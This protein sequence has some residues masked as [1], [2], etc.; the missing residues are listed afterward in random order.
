MSD[1]V[2]KNAG[3]FHGKID[4]IFLDREGVIAHDAVKRQGMKTVKGKDIPVHILEV[5]GVKVEM[6]IRMMSQ[7]SFQKATN[8]SLHGGDQGPAMNTIRYEDGVWK[9]DI[10]VDQRLPLADY[11]KVIGHEFDEIAGIVAKE[12]SRIQ[13]GDYSD[14]SAALTR[15]IHEQQEARVFK[16]GGSSKPEDLT[17]HDRAAMNELARLAN[18]VGS[19]RAGSATDGPQ[20]HKDFTE[21]SRPRAQE[22]SLQKMLDAM[23]ITGMSDPRVKILLDTV[24][25]NLTPD[26]QRWLTNYLYSR[27]L[28]GPFTPKAVDHLLQPN[29]KNLDEHSWSL[30]GIGGGHDTTSLLDMVARAP[31]VDGNPQFKLEHP[32]GKEPF[33]EITSSAGTTKV[34]NWEQYQYVSGKGYVK[35]DVPKTSVDNPAVHMAYLKEFHDAVLMPAIGDGKLDVGLNLLE[36]KDGVVMTVGIKSLNPLEITTIFINAENF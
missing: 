12:N 25:A 19:N 29:P 9:A 17:A 33:L 27:E 3:E 32:P 1:G 13:A 16:D 6:N 30:S 2:A 24:G 28:G 22:Q 20:H 36:N 4:A 23:G 26:A 8:A 15:N 14:D 10:V 5:K 31:K 35:S 11:E 21:G 34:Q 7:E 18:E